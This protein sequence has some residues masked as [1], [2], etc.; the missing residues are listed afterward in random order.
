MVISLTIRNRRDLDLLDESCPQKAKLSS[1]QFL[2]LFWPGV[3][4]TRV[5]SPKKRQFFL[6]KFAHLFFYSLKVQ[7]HIRSP[8]K[9]RLGPKKW[10]YILFQA[11]IFRCEL[12][13]VLG[14]NSSWEKKNM[15]IEGISPLCSKST[16][17][18]LPVLFVGGLLP[19]IVTIAPLFRC[20]QGFQTRRGHWNW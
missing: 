3:S 12:L 8:W 1:T 15:G 6:Q 7:Q 4:P 14:I 17:K 16:L 5:F 9:Y 10:N 19:T 11:S 20:H 13:L 2:P 18:E